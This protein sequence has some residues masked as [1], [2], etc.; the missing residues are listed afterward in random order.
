MAA[1]CLQFVEELRRHDFVFLQ[2]S[3]ETVAANFCCFLFCAEAVCSYFDAPRVRCVFSHVSCQRD[4]RIDV[5][6]QEHMNR[7]ETSKS[8]SSEIHNNST[9]FQI[10]RIT[11]NNSNVAGR[12]R[13]GLCCLKQRQKLTVVFFYIWFDLVL[14]RIKFEF[15]LAAIW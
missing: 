11:E 6:Q 5:R 2:S 4:F 1:L 3:R 7:V 12:P 10:T 14:I 15:E 9:I 8:A 13:E